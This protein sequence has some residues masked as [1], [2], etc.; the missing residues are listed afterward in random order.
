MVPNDESYMD[1][2]NKISFLNKIHF[3]IYFIYSMIGTRK[4]TRY[5]TILNQKRDFK[6]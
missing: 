6:K 1:S 3:L 2:S 4:D 5:T